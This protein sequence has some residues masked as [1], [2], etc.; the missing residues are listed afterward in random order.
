MKEIFKCPLAQPEVFFRESPRAGGV[1][2]TWSA[3]PFPCPV[4]PLPTDLR[5]PEQLLGGES[6]EPTRGR[7]LL[8][9]GRSEEDSACV[10]LGRDDSSEGF[11]WLPPSAFHA[12]KSQTILQ[13][14]LSSQWA[15]IILNAFISCLLSAAS[16]SIGWK[17]TCTNKQFWNHEK[18]ES[19]CHWNRPTI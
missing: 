10:R 19:S 9:H 1:K 11:T 16:A 4:Q 13:K 3:Y 12:R 14:A 2:Y 8:S 7:H 6:A 5:L 18:N 17:L 15:E